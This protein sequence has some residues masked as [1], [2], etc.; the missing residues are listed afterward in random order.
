MNWWYVPKKMKPE[1]VLANTAREIIPCIPQLDVA[2]H[3]RVIRKYMG[4]D[5][6]FLLLSF[7]DLRMCNL[8]L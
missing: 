3:L 2:E 8:D 7:F 1:V 6:V 5:M 4:R